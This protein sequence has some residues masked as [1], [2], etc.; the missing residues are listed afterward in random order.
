MFNIKI[1]AETE[2]FVT[3][4]YGTFGWPIKYFDKAQNLNE[5][6]N[7]TSFNLR[8][9]DNT[10][11]ILF[12]EN[13]D[14]LIENNASRFLDDKKLL[15]GT[16][17]DWS[18]EIT[19]KFPRIVSESSN[20]N[21]AY[22]LKINY[23][24]QKNNNATSSQIGSLFTNSN[25]NTLFA[26]LDTPNIG[27]TDYIF[28]QVT[29]ERFTF[30]EGEL[31][32]GKTFSGVAQSGANFDDNRVILHAQ[33]LFPKKTSGEFYQSSN[34]VLNEGFS[35]EGSFNQ[36]SFL[37]TDIYSYVQ[38]IEENE[39]TELIKILDI[40]AYNGFPGR[41]E[42][43]FILGLSKSEFTALKNVTGL[44]TLHARYIGLENITSFPAEDIN[45]IPYNKYKLN[46]QGLNHN[47]IL[48]KVFPPS[49]IFVYTYSDFV[50]SS[51]GFS[52][53]EPKKKDNTEYI[54]Y[55]KDGNYIGGN[56]ISDKVYIVTQQEYNTAKQTKKWFLINK[57]SNL[58]LENNKSI[59]NTEFTNDAYLVF[60]EA[61]LTGNK[62]TALWIAHTVKN[63]LISKRYNRGAKTFNQLIKTGYSSAKSADKQKNIPTNNLNMN[64]VYARFALIDLLTKGDDPTAKSYFWDGLDLFTKKGEL[65]H[66]KF[67][68]YKSVTIKA[69]H[70]KAAIDFW[71]IPENKNK[72]N[73][74]SVI[75]K[76]FKAEYTLKNVSDG[77][78]LYN[79]DV[80]VGARTDSQDNPKISENLISTGFQSGTMFWTTYKSV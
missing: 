50:F 8:I 13:T 78:I 10:K 42:D 59:I 15:N 67:K 30:I 39:N 5:E 40:A 70:L 75:N 17:T 79:Q 63:A 29:D 58:L 28:Q 69:T 19:L 49:D 24:R 37:K 76:I 56:E 41:K 16:S 35:L 44:S 74:K 46:V 2:S 62:L 20:D 18:N 25:F 34:S 52:N 57:F 73:S 71:N 36:M 1:K 21:L 33:M 77:T 38:S 55:S 3:E 9:D 11:P 27:N 47:G 66:P 60:H 68:Q 53:S 7:Y 12:I 65:D 72:V 61:A 45:G 22:Y 51:K 64:Q 48:T 14:L 4:E 6:Y 54:Y 26:S 31:Q 23:F 32:N 80:F 43:L